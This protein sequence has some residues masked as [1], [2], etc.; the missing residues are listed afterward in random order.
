MVN[1]SHSLELYLNLSRIISLTSRKFS[2]GIDGLGFS[3][4]IILYY[5]SQSSGQKMRR[6]D[7]AD[8]LGLTA[9]GVTRLLQ[10]MEKIGLI[11]KETTPRDLRVSLVS[12]TD[13]GLRNLTETIQRAEELAQSVFPANQV[14][15][16]TVA[17]LFQ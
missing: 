17:K 9:S 13:S 3:E 4:F 8:K 15:D 7:I 1:I 10:G 12:I 16:P 11:R 2:G 5:L 6:I 14:V